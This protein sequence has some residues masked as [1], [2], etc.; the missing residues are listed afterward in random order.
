MS[1][2]KL[3]G[4]KLLDAVRDL[5]GIRSDAALSRELGI[6]PP[7]ICKIRGGAPVTDRVVLRI[8]ERMD[9]PVP[10]IRQMGS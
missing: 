10:Q 8:H 6:K 5:R 9:I 2:A 1:G 7:D 4:A 3:N